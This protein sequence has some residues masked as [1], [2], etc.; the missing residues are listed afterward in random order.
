[1]GISKQLGSEEVKYLL[2]EEGVGFLKRRYTELIFHGNACYEK[3][4]GKGTSIVKSKGKTC[5][6]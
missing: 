5:S 3:T 2:A 4:L 1:M 6:M